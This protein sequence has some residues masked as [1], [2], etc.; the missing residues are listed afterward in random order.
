MPHS[1]PI[2]LVL[3]ILLTPLTLI[4]L[5]HFLQIVAR[6]PLA[7]ENRL[8]SWQLGIFS[9]L[10]ATIA[11]SAALRELLNPLVFAPQI[12]NWI[13][14]LLIKLPPCLFSFSQP[15]RVKFSLD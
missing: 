6:K 14:S 3:P 15:D 9:G 2:S 12:T 4:D 11:G 1:M 10:V 7:D 5:F 13:D 8:P